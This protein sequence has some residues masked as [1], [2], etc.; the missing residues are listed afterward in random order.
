MIRRTRYGEGQRGGEREQ[1]FFWG[2]DEEISFSGGGAIRHFLQISHKDECLDHTGNERSFLQ[3]P[4]T[5]QPSEQTDAWRSAVRVAQE[6]KMT[7]FASSPQKID[8]ALGGLLFYVTPHV[9]RLHCDITGA[10][11]ATGQP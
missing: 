10:Y 1:K 4:L 3:A 8:L 9:Q 5:Q 6:R 11:D 7:C 2:G